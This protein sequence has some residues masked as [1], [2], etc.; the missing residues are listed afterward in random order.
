MSIH[1]Q[2]SQLVIPHYCWWYWRICK[3]QDYSIVERGLYQKIIDVHYSGG[4]K[5][6]EGSRETVT[7]CDKGEGG[8][9]LGFLRRDIL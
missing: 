6:G 9:E 5:G 8:Q 1:F 3:K 7:K 2:L 4:D